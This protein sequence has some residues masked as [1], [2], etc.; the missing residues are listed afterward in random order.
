MNRKCVL[1]RISTGVYLRDFKEFIRI[2]GMSHVSTSP[3]YPQSNRLS[4]SDRFEKLVFNN[5]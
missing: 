3:Y 1:Y 5:S 4:K 2:S